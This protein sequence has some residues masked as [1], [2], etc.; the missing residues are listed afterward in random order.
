MKTI[1]FDNGM[2]WHVGPDS[3][4]QQVENGDDARYLGKYVPFDDLTPGM[5]LVFPDD[6]RVKVVRIVDVSEIDDTFEQ[7]WARMRR[8]GFQYGPDARE[9]VR[10]GWKLARGE[11]K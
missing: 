10:F 2:R 3:F 4:I 6:V 1:T 5:A 9:Q 11:I 8:K 7:A